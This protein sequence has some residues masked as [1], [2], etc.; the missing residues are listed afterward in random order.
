MTLD[1]S[2]SGSVDVEPDRTSYQ[3]G[4]EVT[5]T[6]VADPGWVF[7]GWSGDISGDTNPTTVTVQH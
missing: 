3:Y 2:G 4:E 5:L 1:V 6:A 7:V